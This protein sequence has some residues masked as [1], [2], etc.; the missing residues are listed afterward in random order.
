CNYEIR[1]S[2]G[3][4]ASKALQDLSDDTGLPPLCLDAPVSS[5][6][7]KLH[8]Y[9]WAMQIF[10]Q[11][12]FNEGAY[13]FALAAL[14]QVDEATSTRDESQMEHTLE[15]SSVSVKGRL[16][17]NVF[18][19]TL[20][21]NR[22]YDAYC[23]IISNPDEESKQICLRRFIIVLYEHGAM[24]VLCDGKLPFT[25]LAEKIERELASK[26]DRADILAKP[27][28]YKLL[29]AFEMNRHNW[30]KAAGYMYEYSF[31]LKTEVLVKDQKHSSLFLQ[32]RL[33]GISAAINALHLVHPAYAWFD[34][35]SEKKSRSNEGYPNKKARKTENE[36]LPQGH[37]H[38]HQKE[39]EQS[40]IDLGK[41]EDEFVLTSA[42]YTLSL[43]NIEW[44]STG[45]EAP[46]VLVDALIQANLYDMAF[47]VILKFWK[48][49][50]LTRE[51]ER[52]FSAMSLKCFPNKISST[53]TEMNQ[54]L[55]TSSE[56]NN[57]CSP[58]MGSMYQQPKG[59]SQRSIKP[60][61][62]DCQ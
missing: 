23:A 35:Q 6:A 9:Q 1:A 55:L 47:T 33:N 26:A 34:S 22:F 43:A 41:L 49:S 5:A 56:E 20:D 24:K 58:G 51:L 10:E 27:N 3:E 13:Q 21:L 25:G 38:G 37:G 28:L 52:A 15:E 57:Q 7:W 2:S 14:E 62:L 53:C 48:G 46:S 54:L 17:A 11:Y 50:G 18:K 32:E 19:F 39:Q 12:S 4:Q 8:Y 31:R 36:Q 45:K 61:M 16:W 42:E 60:S 44:I 29:Y 40:Y 30:R 59:N